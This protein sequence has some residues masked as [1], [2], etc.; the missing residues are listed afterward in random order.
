[1]ATE[2]TQKLVRSHT[3]NNKILRIRSNLALNTRY[4][5][6]GELIATYYGGPGTIYFADDKQYSVD[7]SYLKWVETQV[8]P[9]DAC[10]ISAFYD[11]HYVEVLP[12][13]RSDMSFYGFDGTQKHYKSQGTTVPA[14]SE[15]PTDGVN[16]RVI[17]CSD[18]VYKTQFR[19]A[20]F[21]SER[22]LFRNN[23]FVGRL[24]QSNFHGFARFEF[25]ADLTL[26]EQV[27]LA[28]LLQ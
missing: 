11:Y 4:Y 19:K 16:E 18:R 23:D 13:V 15:S 27:F 28:F 14:H 26:T 20:F 6:D 21:G 25:A 22:M 17:V 10:K 24:K 1:M 5:S 7:C 9:K 12:G 2:K 3:Q 8:Y